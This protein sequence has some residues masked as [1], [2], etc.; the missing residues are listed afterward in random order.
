MAA[1][2]AGEA[3]EAGLAQKVLMA[4]GLYDPVVPL[5]AGERSLEALRA[6]GVDVVLHRYPMQ[7]ELC[8]QELADIAAWLA[9]RLPPL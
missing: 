9:V 2:V 5:S 6:L 7:H 4:H 1:K 3:T 8:G